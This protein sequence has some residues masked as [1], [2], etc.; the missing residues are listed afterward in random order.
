M[1]WVRLRVKPPWSGGVDVQ[2]RS[3]MV[4]HGARV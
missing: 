1:E 2:R 3:L 4:N